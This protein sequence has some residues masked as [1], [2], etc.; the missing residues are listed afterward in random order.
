MQIKLFTVS[1]GDEGRQQVELN[2][3]LRGKHK[4]ITQAMDKNKNTFFYLATLG[5]FVFLKI[6]YQTANNDELWFLLKPIDQLVC[7]LTDSSSVYFSDNGY[8]HHKLNILID[9]SCSGFNYWCISFVV[10]SITM[11]KHNHTPWYKTVA[12]P[13]SLVLA[14]VHTLL[15]NTSRIYVSII[16]EKHTPTVFADQQHLIHEAIGIVT[17]FSFL[18]LSYYLILKTFQHRPHYASLT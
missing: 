7:L 9:K 10:F 5:I 1:I 16:A 18:I 13:V 8:Y 4:K 17:N 6:G 12:I 11:I 15:V 14:Y 2:A 3:F